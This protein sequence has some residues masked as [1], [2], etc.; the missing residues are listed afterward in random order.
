M[1]APR[2][3]HSNT[4]SAEPDRRAQYRQALAGPRPAA[5]ALVCCTGMLRSSP[6]VKDTMSSQ[7]V[8]APLGDGRCS[9]EVGSPLR[10]HSSPTPAS[11]LGPTSRIMRVKMRPLADVEEAFPKAG[12]DLKANPPDRDLPVP[13]QYS[14]TSTRVPRVLAA[15]LGA[16]TRNRTRRP[17]SRSRNS[18]RLPA[19]TTQGRY[20]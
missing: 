7:V 9:F 10:G 6:S 11:Q 19:A 5:R 16:G 4:P 13:Q 18:S 20:R 14:P 17:T 8:E 1:R 12:A 3:R 2:R 15:A